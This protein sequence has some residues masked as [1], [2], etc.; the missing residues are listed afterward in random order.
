MH[1]YTAL[2]ENLNTEGDSSQE[3]IVVIARYTPGFYPPLWHDASFSELILHYMA[4][5]YLGK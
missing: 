1:Q 4:L 3:Y 2:V 5:L